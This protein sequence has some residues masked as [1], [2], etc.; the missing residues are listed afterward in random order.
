MSG[1]LS[2]IKNIVRWARITVAGGDIASLPIQQVEYKGKVGDCLMV[3]PYGHHANLTENSLV[4]MFAMEGD[5]NSRAGIGYTPD[6]RPT[7]KAG[8]V[9]IYHPLTGTIIKFNEAGGININA[10]AAITIDAPDITMNSVNHTINTTNYELNCVEGDA[11][12]TG[13]G[14][15]FTG[16]LRSNTEDI[17]YQRT[18]GGVQSGSSS[19]DVV[20]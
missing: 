11:V 7:L 6:V 1:L 3:F 14:F 18:H 13:T 19:T 12:A 15:E 17:S 10:V 16:G 5:A 4:A 2:R 8:E 9:A 20:D